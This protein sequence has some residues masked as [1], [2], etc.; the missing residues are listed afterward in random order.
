MTLVSMF[1]IFFVINASAENAIWNNDKKGI[2]ERLQDL[3]D[4]DDAN[5]NY[6]IKLT[7]K[8]DVKEEQI[9][10]LIDENQR[11]K[12]Q[13]NLLQSNQDESKVIIQQLLDEVNNLKIDLN[14]TNLEVKNQIIKM[15]EEINK[16]ILEMKVGFDNE[17]KENFE[18]IDNNKNVFNSQVIEL[19]EGIEDLDTKVIEMGEGINECLTDPPPCAENANC[20]D[21]PTGNNFTTILSLVHTFQ[22]LYIDAEM[23]FIHLILT[24]F[25]LV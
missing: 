11:L 21:L 1:L 4:Q 9:D 22:K 16:E 12:K 19:R 5:K 15:K 13:V 14:D 10:S 25:E 6:I 18:S 23:M 3:Y 7:S 24:K 8:L 17:M 2:M 20:K